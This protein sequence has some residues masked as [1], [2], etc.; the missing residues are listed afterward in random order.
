M[1]KT[2]FILLLSISTLFAEDYCN[3]VENNAKGKKEYSHLLSLCGYSTKSAGLIH[4][5]YRSTKNIPLDQKVLIKDSDLIENDKYKFARGEYFQKIF[6]AKTKEEYNDYL[7]DVRIYQMRKRYINAL[8]YN[9][10]KN[11]SR[12]RSDCISG[13]IIEGNQIIGLKNGEFITVEERGDYILRWYRDI[14]GCRLEKPEDD[15]RFSYDE[16]KKYELQ[17]HQRV[18]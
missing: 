13:A 18:R 3:F 8:K 15:I 10:D 12:K 4:D 2:T 1:Y 11:F 17:H 16:L 5:L 6:T 9:V 7:E 14:E